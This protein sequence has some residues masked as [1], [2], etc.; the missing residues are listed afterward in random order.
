MSDSDESSET[1]SDNS[2]HNTREDL[3][4]NDVKLQ[5]MRRSAQ[6]RGGQ[7]KI[8][9]RFEGL[10]S[11]DEMLRQ[12][13][14]QRMK[15]GIQKILSLHTPVELSSLCGCL[16]LKVQEK[17]ST[18]IHFITQYASESK[19]LD[20]ERLRKIMNFMW[21]GALWE[22]LHSIGHPIHS[23]RPDP[24]KTILDIWEKGGLLGGNINGFVP[25]FIAREVKKRN[26]W[27]QSPDIQDRLEKLRKAQD[28]AKSAERKIISDHDYTNI[29]SYFNQMGALRRLENSVREFLIS[30]VEIVRSRID[31]CED[32]AKMMRQ[33]LKEN[34]LHYMK[35][36]DTVNEQ[37]ALT[38][39]VCEERIAERYQLEGDVQRLGNV[40]ESYIAAEENREMIG[41]GTMQALKLRHAEKCNP[42]VRAIHAQVQK[43]KQ[44]RDHMDSVL[45]AQARAQR[46]DV[47]HLNEMVDA[48]QAELEALNEHSVKETARADAA[49]RALFFCRRKLAKAENRQ[50][51][52]AHESW[53]SSARFTTKLD[54]QLRLARSIRPVMVA[55]LNHPHRTV[56]SLA[57]SV[58]STFDL[59]SKEE[60]DRVYETACMRRQDALSFAVRRADNARRDAMN[61]PAAVAARSKPKV[62]IAKNGKGGSTKTTKSTGSVASKSSRASTPSETSRAGRPSS[63]PGTPT[64]KGGAKS[65]TSAM[66]SPS[67]AKKKVL[68]K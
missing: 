28:A 26:E 46:N 15:D 53:G 4:A 37:L 1:I 9:A 29:L 59:A 47:S 66:K 23:M 48:L 6:K 22:Y 36:V 43:Y 62:K 7:S 44:V 32:S 19:D 30:E 52:A 13:A 11:Y 5:Q 18:S 2:E 40:I 60:I 49:E 10:V 58:L 27:I 55:A 45:R 64:A 57:R 56:I 31:S 35:V 34:E 14:F 61:S 68:K 38:E 50:N 21:E 16:G 67:S 17:G 33:Q 20:P 8:V 12:H 24:K 42:S 41:G 63:K 65:P 54:H 25:H 3:N 51:I 39:F